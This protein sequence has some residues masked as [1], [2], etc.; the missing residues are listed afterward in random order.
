MDAGIPPVSHTY[1]LVLPATESIPTAQEVEALELRVQHLTHVRERGRW[2][3]AAQTVLVVLAGLLWPYLFRSWLPSAL[4]LLLSASSTMLLGIQ[5]G[6]LQSGD[7]N[8][9]TPFLRLC[10]L[11]FGLRSHE[12]RGAALDAAIDAHATAYITRSLTKED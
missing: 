6:R 5:Y 4:V 7:C 3:L 9:R 11:V 2:S 1:P 8:K 10:A 12:E